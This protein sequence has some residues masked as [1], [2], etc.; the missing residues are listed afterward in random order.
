MKK[1][2][3]DAN[4]EMAEILELS[5]KDFKTTIIKMLQ[6]AV[7]NMLNQTKKRALAKK[8]VFNKELEN[9]RTKWKL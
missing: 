9:I 7:I 2:S 6:W 8:K 1:K 3:I 5:H 4:T